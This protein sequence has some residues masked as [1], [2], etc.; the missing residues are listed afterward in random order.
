M[1]RD[2]N[3]VTILGRLGGDPELRHTQAGRQVANF[4]CATNNRYTNAAGDKVDDVSWHRV[5]VWGKVADVAA[6]YLKK[7]SRVY[8]EGRLQ[9]RKWTDNEGVDRQACEVVAEDLIFLDAAPAAG[10][11]APSNGRPVAVPV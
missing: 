9:Y 8:L 3:K 6:K 11:D 2:L 4:S 10:V 7:G 5:V 1:A